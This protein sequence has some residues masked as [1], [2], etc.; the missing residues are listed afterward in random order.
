[1]L[2][3]QDASRTLARHPTS[4]S[5]D[6]YRAVAARTSTADGSKY[7]LEANLISRNMKSFFLGNG[8]SLLS[9]A[10]ISFVGEVFAYGGTM[11]I[12]YRED[13]AFGT[14]P[15]ELKMY[16]DTRVVHRSDIGKS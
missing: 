16:F 13:G 7:D 15:D 1:M 6:F 5:A 2:Q 12:G 11:A 4:P 14:L 3:L 8:H 9:D 10:T